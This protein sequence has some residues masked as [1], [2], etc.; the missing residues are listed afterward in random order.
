MNIVEV[1]TIQ[2]ISHNQSA[3]QASLELYHQLGAPRSGFVLFYCSAAYPLLDLGKALKK[4]FIDVELAGCT[5]AGETTRHGYHQ[6]SIVAIWFNPDFF[7]ISS[8]V[9]M[10]IEDFDLITAQRQ[11]NQLREEC[12]TSIV[13]FGAAKPFLITLIDGLSAQEEKF[14]NTLNSAANGIPHFGGSAG[15]D[16]NLANTH[17]FHHGT[18]IH[19]AAVVV[20]VHSRCRFEVF[21]SHHISNSKHKMVV[22][23]ADPH[24]RIVYE[25]NSEP[26]AKEY[27]NFLGISVEELTPETFALHPLAVKIG[28]RYY[29]RSIQKVNP[30][31]LS[32]SFYCAVDI[33][34]VLNTVE[35]RDIVTS[36][37]TT[38]YDLQ[39]RH[40]YPETVLACDCVLRRLEIEQKDQMMDM[41]RLQQKFKVFGFNTYGEH[42][43]GVHLNQTFTGVYISGE[44]YE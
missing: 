31:D 37:E 7:S 24:S 6:H 30:E 14:L 26:A 5:T 10:S 21:Q 9:V 3:Y 39:Q 2:A 8:S 20:M 18:F 22:T 34:I 32:L 15:D 35:M 36:L 11:I 27:A 28:D 29:S 19:N 25:L 12:A 4:Q 41:A 13:N 16:I 43:N 44:C 42:L 40:L 23:D 1:K 17:V 38:L 33:G